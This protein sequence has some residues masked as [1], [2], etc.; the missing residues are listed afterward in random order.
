MGNTVFQNRQC[1]VE[2]VDNYQTWSFVQYH[3]KG[4]SMS[5]YRSELANP[6]IK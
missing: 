2:I 6:D 1:F 5:L 3:R 4:K